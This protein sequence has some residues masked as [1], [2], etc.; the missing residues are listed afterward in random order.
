M[1]KKRS[2]LRSNDQPETRARRGRS[3]S[4]QLASQV[5]QD[6][7]L[8]AERSLQIDKSMVRHLDSVAAT[9][10]HLR[11][12]RVLHDDTAVSSVTMTPGW[13]KYLDG[14]FRLTRL[15][16]A[17]RSRISGSDDNSLTEQIRSLE[18]VSKS[19]EK[20]PKF[21]HR[22]K[23]VL[24]KGV[25][26][27]LFGAAFDSPKAKSSAVPPV[28]PE[29]IS[30]LSVDN[31]EDISPIVTR[32]FRKRRR[33]IA[34]LSVFKDVFKDSASFSSSSVTDVP[35]RLEERRRRSAHLSASPLKN[36]KPGNQHIVT[37]E[38]NSGTKT[39]AGINTPSITK[40]FKKGQTGLESLSV[41][42]SEN[43]ESGDESRQ[44][45]A[46]LS[47]ISSEKRRS[48]NKSRQKSAIISVT[49]PENKESGD[50]SR[51][52]SA[53]LSVTAPENESGDESR[54]MSARLSF[55]S[56]E[57]RRSRNKSRQKSAIISV[58]APENKESGDESRQKSANLSV[59][60]PENESGDESRQMSARL[61]FISSEKRRSRNKSRQKSAIIS[62]TA[63]ENKESGDES[64][65]KSA[66][67]SVTAPENESGDESRQM[68][69]RLSF[70]SSEKRRSR[71][72]SRQKSAIISVT[73]P[74]NKES[75]DESRQKSANLSFISPEKRRSRNKSRQKSAIISVTAPDNKESGDELRQKSANLSFISPEKRRSRNKSRQKSAIIS[76]TAP[77]NESGDESRQKSENLSVVVA[78]DGK[79]GDKL[80]QKSALLLVTTHNSNRL[81][82]EHV[83][84]K[85]QQSSPKRRADI[86]T[87]SV[88]KVSGKE[89]TELESADVHPGSVSD[90]SEMDQNGVQQ[91][92]TQGGHNIFSKSVK[93]RTAPWF[94][95]EQEKVSTSKNLC[96]FNLLP[97][98]ERSAKLRELVSGVKKKYDDALKPNLT[99]G[100]FSREHR[101][102]R[103]IKDSVT[104]RERTGGKK[105]IHPALLVDGKRYRPRLKRP[106]SWATPRLYKLL[107]PKCEEKYGMLKA[108]CKAEEFVIFL[109]EKVSTVIR[110]KKYENY[111][112][113]LEE[114]KRALYKLGIIKCLMEYF[115]FIEDYLPFQYRIKA[116]PCLR[117][118][119]KRTGPPLAPGTDLFADLGY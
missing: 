100:L 64:R 105:K 78:E 84:T 21:E 41:T 85:E 56:S 26:V 39:Q 89:Q 73:A 58:T 83:D 110:R 52:K 17:K 50:E 35:D 11:P 67:L 118:Y 8:P 86:N 55:I 37:S 82:N 69:A 6:R 44:K 30:D 104:V 68:S 93:P 101:E 113:I 115:V 111:E 18:D 1:E 108:R 74:E 48:R 112:S 72:K 54:Q 59:T 77:E 103:N 27:E 9:P 23:N 81:G 90:S 4:R 51:Q 106:K 102:I 31:F 10:E 109:C 12:Q 70:I 57:K 5:V 16:A 71:N 80:R 88:S 119:G 13:T 65:Q 117:G 29:R 114:I 25:G 38:Q 94:G 47:F 33:V 107:I 14:T 3:S 98:E 36:N 7:S 45:S 79:S 99:N 91:K 49:A 63:P 87:P 97:R 62:V 96:T 75:G 15:S 32:P 60:A 34:D 92:A 66:N 116:I 40:K 2:V 53:N 42:S 24:P 28:Q 19:P 43:K 76:V 95:R 46:S 20:Q 61:S 22:R